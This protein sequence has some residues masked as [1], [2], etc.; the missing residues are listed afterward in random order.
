[1]QENY[2]NHQPSIAHNEA[3]AMHVI[4]KAADAMSAADIT[5]K[6]IRMQQQWHLAPAAVTLSAVY[7][8]CYM[9][10]R[11]H[12]SSARLTCAALPDC[13]RHLTLSA[14]CGSPHPPRCC[15]TLPARFCCR[16]LLA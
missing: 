6:R 13:F 8:A 4:A 2:L 10:Y 9:R 14:C 11:P 16:S 1:M 12:Q 7:P 5:N 15:G 3:V